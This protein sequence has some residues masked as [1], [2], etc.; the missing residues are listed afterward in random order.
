MILGNDVVT[1][2]F[3]NESLVKGVA[4]VIIN[5]I[6]RKGYEIMLLFVDIKAELVREGF[7]KTFPIDIPSGNGKTSPNED[8]NIFLCKLLNKFFHELLYLSIHV[9]GTRPFPS[10][11][12]STNPRGINGFQSTFM[13]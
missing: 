5:M 4:L 6:L 8:A 3:V 7:K 12:F 11:F 13:L 1:A 9:F 10:A 2:K